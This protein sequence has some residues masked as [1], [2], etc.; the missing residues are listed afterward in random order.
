MDPIVTNI[1]QSGAF[2]WAADYQDNLLTFAGAATIAAGTILARDTATQ[3]L[4]PFIKGDAGDAG[5][6]VTVI[7]FD[8]T[9]EAAGDQS[10]RTPQKARIDLAKLIIDADGDSSNVDNVVRDQLREQN[11]TVMDVTQL[12]E[13]DNQ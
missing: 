12:S 13:L 11:I 7:G 4:I 5:I 8:V 2:M 10:V 1:D 3:K 6:P 9:A